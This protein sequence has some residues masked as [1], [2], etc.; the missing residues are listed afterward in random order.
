MIDNV[1]HVVYTYPK[2]EKKV[3]TELQRKNIN[4]Y[5]PLQKVLR[6]WSDRKKELEVPLF[7]NYVF[8]QIS[9]TDQHKVISIPG[10]TKFIK[11]NGV[12]ASITNH[13]VDIIKLLLSRNLVIEKEDF[14]QPG[15]RVKVIQGPLAGLAG[16]LL[17]RKGSS[18]FAIHFNSIAQAMSIEINSKYLQ[19]IS[20]TTLEPEFMESERY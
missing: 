12:P 6:Q 14:Y 17:E 4:A 18:R 7:P 9:R 11:F 19:R 20:Q 2:Q 15:D 13:E 10:V 8:V 1:W 5:L 16:L 3:F